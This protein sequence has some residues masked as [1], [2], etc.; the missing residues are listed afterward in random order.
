MPDKNF[1]EQARNMADGFNMEPAPANWESIRSAIGRSKRKRRIAFWWWLLPLCTAAG[2]AVYT[3][4]LSDKQAPPAAST[5]IARP[6]SI[7]KKKK[8]ANGLAKPD[9]QVVNPA[10]SAE[11]VAG[12]IQKKV[13]VPKELALHQEGDTHL[14]AFNKSNIPAAVK[15]E[16][17]NNAE[18]I[19]TNKIADMPTTVSGNKPNPVT[20]SVGALLPIETAITDSFTNALNN[21]QTAYSKVS[22]AAVSL[23]NDSAITRQLPKDTAATAALQKHNKV[24]GWHLGLTAEGGI[25]A[26]SASLLA[27]ASFEKNAAPGQFFLNDPGT[28]TSG[29]LNS[30]GISRTTT[31]TKPGVTWSLGIA[32]QKGLSHRIDFLTNVA[33]HYETLHTSTVTYSDSLVLNNSFSTI[34]GSYKAVQQ[35]QF[36][37]LFTGFNWHFINSKK[38]SA[39]VSIGTDNFLLLAAKQKL[40]NVNGSLASRNN[41]QNISDSV[42]TTDKYYRYQPGFFAG[43]LVNINMT[44]GKQLQFVPFMRGGLKQFEKNTAATNN[45]LFSAGLRAIFFFK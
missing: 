44:G 2:I 34:A 5:S 38:I 39:G 43:I 23:T 6:Y 11:I 33:Y 19:T 24:S 26:K 36:A 41:L 37:S 18:S 25:V 28:I 32:L 17:L 12:N 10:N 4:L 35:F 27:L 1:E 15:K 30:A 42:F 3:Q 40:N 13:E 20:S 21:T 45:H 31:Q 16:V 14:S 7:I 8:A 22:G 29:G 9:K